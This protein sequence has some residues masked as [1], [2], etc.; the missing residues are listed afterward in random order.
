MPLYT[1]FLFFEN[2]KHKRITYNDK[3]RTEKENFKQIKA[4]QNYKK[5][6]IDERNI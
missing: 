2:A 3:K 5:T 1:K 4:H 6:K